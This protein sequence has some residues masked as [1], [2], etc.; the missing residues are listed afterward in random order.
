MI[1]NPPSNVGDLSL[2]R[3]WGTKIPH[4]EVGQLN[5]CT[6]TTEPSTSTREKPVCRKE[7]PVYCS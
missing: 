5:M 4:A 7:D 3:S 6:A 1:T 2:I